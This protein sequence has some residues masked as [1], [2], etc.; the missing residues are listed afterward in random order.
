MLS[1]A[2]SS[3]VPYHGQTI[4]GAVSQ[5]EGLGLNASHARSEV[6]RQRD[7]DINEYSVADFL[8]CRRS[9]SE[10]SPAIASPTRSRLNLGQLGRKKEENLIFKISRKP[11][12]FACPHTAQRS[13][14]RG[15]CRK[16]YA[17]VGRTKLSTACQHKRRRM[18]CKKMCKACYL[19]V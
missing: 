10:G 15:Y 12:C 7:P 16:C 5:G 8:Q 18:F 6:Q 14:C 13:F 3:S 11:L 1:Q 17:K 4:E 2:D 19:K 9:L